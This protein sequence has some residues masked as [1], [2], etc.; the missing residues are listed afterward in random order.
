MDDAALDD[1]LRAGKTLLPP[2]FK[3]SSLIYGK[4]PLA[5]FA[6]SGGLSTG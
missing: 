1:H 4:P 6:T 2:Y 5:A 3:S